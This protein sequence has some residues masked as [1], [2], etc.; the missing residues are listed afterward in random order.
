MRSG[1]RATIAEGETV[2]YPVLAGDGM[3]GWLQTGPDGSAPSVGLRDLATGTVGT[4]ALAGEGSG[5]SVGDLGMAGATLIWTLGGGQGT[6]LVVHDVPSR[7]SRVA[8]RGAI[9]APATDGRVVVWA[10]EDDASGNPV[11]RGLTLADDTGFEVGRPSVWP[12]SLAV[13][14]GWIAWASDD[15][16]W[17]YLDAQR[18][19]R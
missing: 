14:G 11:I 15:G 2:D 10:A 9:H 7:V 18:M 17:S 13:G 3:V 19:T 12:T 8:A 4:V 5:V 16:S 1:E 6:S